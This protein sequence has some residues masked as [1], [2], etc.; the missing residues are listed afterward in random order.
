[1]IEHRRSSAARVS[2]CFHGVGVPGPGIDSGAADY[3]VS[4]DVFL[5]VLD[6]VMQHPSVDLTFDDGYASD[7]DIVLPA[8][9]ERGLRARFFPLAGRLHSPGYVDAVGVRALASAGMALG[10][11]G[12]RHRSWRGLDAASTRE[13]LA[14]ARSV[15][16]GAAGQPV[17]SVACP[18]GAYDRHVLAALREHGYSLVFTSDRRRARAGAWLQPRYSIRRNDTVRTVRDDILAPQ[19]LH[20]RMR[21]GVA[22]RVKALL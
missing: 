19:S 17:T 7:V 4:R 16:A 10:S 13:E 1:M 14:V 22:G 6:E 12:M 18:F 3:F 15:I 5:A 8:L 21:T 9:S 20:A 11:H 2:I